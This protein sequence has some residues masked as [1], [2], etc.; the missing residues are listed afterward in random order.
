MV[1]LEIPI[2]RQMRRRVLKFAAAG[3]LAASLGCS[4]KGPEKFRCYDY[5]DQTLRVHVGDNEYPLRI[6]GEQPMDYFCTN[7]G[8]LFWLTKDYLYVKKLSRR[9]SKIDMEELFKDKHTS[10][11][12]YAVEGV[13]VVSGDIW[14]N[15]TA[16]WENVNIATITN[17]GF[18]Q[19]VRYSLSDIANNNPDRGTKELSM[20]SELNR[21]PG[22][23]ADASVR[24]V[25]E[26][27]FVVVP[28]GEKGKGEFKKFYVISFEGEKGSRFYGRMVSVTAKNLPLLY[29]DLHNIVEITSPIRYDRSQSGWVVNLLGERQDGSTFPI[30]VNVVD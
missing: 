4:R 29:T 7:S 14:D 23:A 26:E 13:K 24:I 12:E 6:D 2:V 21:W 20:L 9:G 16:N 3:I 28:T 17:T 5:Q 19:T 30:L 27:H 25:G 11:D 1:F 8:H 18:F 22:T 15:P 10:P